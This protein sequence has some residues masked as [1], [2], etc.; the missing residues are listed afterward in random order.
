MAQ[1]ARVFSTDDLLWYQPPG[2]DRAYSKMLM[3]P[4]RDSKVIDMRLSRLP[5]GG[6]ID[7]HT[8]ERAEHVYYIL[9][10][11]AAAVLD[12]ETHHV[13]ANSVLYI[14]PGV[15]HGFD[16]TGNEDLL[17]TVVSVPADDMPQV[18]MTR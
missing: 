2:H 13:T 1:R 14:P 8:H 18:A 6:H 11:H 12:G 16:S 17:M 5:P 9:Q 7:E 3:E 15:R 4:A 10:G